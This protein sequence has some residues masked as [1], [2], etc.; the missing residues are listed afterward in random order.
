MAK[1]LAVSLFHLVDI[2]Y[3][4]KTVTSIRRFLQ[5][6]GTNRFRYGNMFSTLSFTV[7]DVIECQYQ[8]FCTNVSV[9]KVKLLAETFIKS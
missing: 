2:K 6:F 4:C 7:L 8:L 1:L 9:S 3:P 5:F